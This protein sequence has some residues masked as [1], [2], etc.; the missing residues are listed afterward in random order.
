MRQQDFFP[1]SNDHCKNNQRDR[2]VGQHW[3]RR[4]C[5]RAARAGKKFTPH[6]LGRSV[7][8]AAHY[9]DNGWRSLLLPDVS[10]W[11]SPGEDHEIKHKRPTDHGY[12]GLEDYRYRALWEFFL[13]SGR[14]VFYTIHK[15]APEYGVLSEI[16]RDEDWLTTSIVNLHL[17]ILDGKAQHAWFNSWVGGEKKRVPGWFWPEELWRPLI[18]QWAAP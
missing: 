6:Q 1:T 14:D 11:T 13:E 2:K 5:L 17:A 10:I 7:A 8:A 18:E 4:F 12:F 16:D 9:L 15:Y 3:E